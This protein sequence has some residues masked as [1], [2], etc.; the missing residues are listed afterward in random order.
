MNRL[1]VAFAVC[2]ACL[3]GGFTFGISTQK[4]R[5]AKIDLRH[6][7]EQVAAAHEIAKKEAQ[8]LEAESV[9]TALGLEL[10]D[11]AHADFSDD[12]CGISVERV[13]R[14]KQR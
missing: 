4:G 12:A 5:Q 6:Q 13:L 10:E 7:R 11:L 2:I 1:T 14:L 9:R 3:V 8:R